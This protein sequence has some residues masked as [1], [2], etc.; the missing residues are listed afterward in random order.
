M[1]LAAASSQKASFIFRLL[2]W[3]KPNK[4]NFGK[5]PGGALVLYSTGFWSFSIIVFFWVHSIALTREG[6]C[7]WVWVCKERK[8]QQWT[9][10]NNYIILLG[11]V[12]DSRRIGLSLFKLKWIPH[13]QIK[14]YSF[15]WKNYKFPPS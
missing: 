1:V 7:I 5:C 12:G 14:Y 11:Q 2:H 9:S 4:I 3:L 15:I 10:H 6:S 13:F 8:T